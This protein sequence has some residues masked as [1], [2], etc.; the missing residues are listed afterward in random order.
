M[1]IQD[2]L[3]CQLIKPIQVASTSELHE[4]QQNDLLFFEIV[5]AISAGPQKYKNQ[6]VDNYFTFYNPKK[7]QAFL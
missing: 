5:P 4:N 2:V 1:N 3:W 6:I 7:F